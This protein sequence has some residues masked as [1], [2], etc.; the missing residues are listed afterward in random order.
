MGTEKVA[1]VTMDVQKE[2]VTVLVSWEGTLIKRHMF[3]QGVSWFMTLPMR[4]Y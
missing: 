3:A 2:K 4:E 1:V